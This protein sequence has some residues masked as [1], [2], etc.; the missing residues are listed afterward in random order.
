MPAQGLHQRSRGQGLHLQHHGGVALRRSGGYRVARYVD[1]HGHVCAFYDST[2]LFPADASRTRAQAGTYVLDMTNPRKPGAH[3]Q[4]DDAGDGLA[5]R[6]AAA[7]PEAR[8][9]R[10]RCRARPR[11]TPAFVDVYGVNDDCR[12]PVWRASLPIGPLGHESGFSP[13]GRT[14]WATATAR[15][16]ITAIDLTTPALPRIIWHT[17]TYGSHGM[18]ISQDGKRAYLASP[19]CNYFTAVGGYGN[20]SKTGGLII[21]DISKIQNRTIATPADSVPVVA[22]LSWPEISIP[23]NVIPITVKRPPLPG[24]VRR[25]QLQRVPVQP[26]QQ[27]RRRPH[28]R[29]RQREEAAGHQPDPPCG[30]QQPTRATR[31]AERPWRNKRRRRAMPRTTAPCRGRTT[32]AS[33]RAA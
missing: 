26:R 13:D 6:V 22:K 12:H 18:A 33:W 8:P 7:Q 27:R 24:G 9:A 20:D 4:P 21:L 19:C 28:H 17:E 32:R 5:A 31:P 16:G 15:E 23:Q 14:F 2:L 29:H 1:K 30:S 11:P 10:R 3:G 25:V